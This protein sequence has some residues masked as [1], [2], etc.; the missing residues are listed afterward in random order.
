MLKRFLEWIGLKEKLHNIDNDPPLVKERDL[1]WVSFGEN[2]GSEMNGKSRLFSRPG[3]I[4]KKLSR[5]F[6]LVAPTTSQKK[7]GTWY[8]PIKQEGR[9]MYVCLHQIR[10]IDYRRLSSRLGRMDEE[11]FR[12]VK[13]TFWRL[14][15]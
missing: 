4:I 15:K 7:E 3:V 10:T 1:W 12:R 9:D 14:Y 5:G 11:D 6:F 13:E 8:M 2:I